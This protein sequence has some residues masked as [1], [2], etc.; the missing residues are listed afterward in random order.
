MRISISLV[1]ASLSFAA[2]AFAAD[3]KPGQEEAKNKFDSTMKPL[4]TELNAQCGTTLDGVR[5]DFES[6]DKAGFVQ[7]P[8]AQK[9]TTL[10]YAVKTTCQSAPYKK[11]FAKKVKTIACLMGDGNPFELVGDVFTY[12]MGSKSSANG[13][14]A[15]NA[16]KAALDK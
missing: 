6:Y 1:A 3:L 15:T 14:D 5:S 4:V 7:M 8:P 11:A 9:C 13:I 2:V 12:R 16:L 10:T